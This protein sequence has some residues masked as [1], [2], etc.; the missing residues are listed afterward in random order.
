MVFFFLVE[1][2]DQRGTSFHSVHRHRKI[3]DRMV[4]KKRSPHWD[5]NGMSETSE[6]FTHLFISVT[7]VTRLQKYTMRS[8]FIK[9]QLHPMLLPI[10]T[11]S[12]WCSSPEVHIN[13]GFEVDLSQLSGVHLSDL[14]VTVELHSRQQQSSTLI[15]VA[16]LPISQ[17][18]VVEL[19]GRNAVFYFKKSRINLQKPGSTATVAKLVVT[20]AAGY[21]DQRA[22]IDPPIKFMQVI[23]K[24][25]AA[26][27][28]R[29]SMDEEK[30]KKQAQWK[31]RAKEN[32]YL[33]EDEVKEMWEVFAKAN[34]WVPPTSDVSLSMSG[35]VE[36]AN[37]DPC[38]VW[39]PKPVVEV[40]VKGPKM[41][42]HS[43]VIVSFDPMP[44]GR[45]CRLISRSVSVFDLFRKHAFR[46]FYDKDDE[47]DAELDSHLSRT[48]KNRKKM[49]LPKLP[50][51]AQTPCS[52]RNWKQNMNGISASPAVPKRRD[53][54]TLSP[55]LERILS[56]SEFIEGMEL[57]LSDV[58][59]DD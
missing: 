18:K 4:K 36:D 6:Q 2:T 53:E 32:G 43:D 40:S 42:I 12:V 56:G 17:K 37:I 1:R 20:M 58:E 34:G 9:T 38:F 46:S 21:E 13:A 24:E 11:H 15:G 14:N 29:L 44:L 22:Y 57:H 10:T 31:T 3:V 35:P 39:P 50:K 27:R 7:S 33:P 41:A 25:N 48:L 47:T 49:R 28:R 5:F 19:N 55:S 23:A 52:M 16:E 26:F 8:L 54:I 45:S 30:L 59:S 51:L